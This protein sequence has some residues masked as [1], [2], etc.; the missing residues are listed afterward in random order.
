MGTIVRK[1]SK[2]SEAFLKEG[3]ANGRLIPAIARHMMTAVPEFRRQDVLHPS[4]M[5]KKDWCPLGGYRQ[6]QGWTAKKESIT[7][8]R[9]NI[10]DEGHAIHDKWQTRIAQM[11]N[12]YGVWQC[13]VCE[14]KWWDTSPG[15]CIACGSYLLKYREVPVE[16]KRTRIGGHTDGWVKGQGP[17]YMLEIKSV[18]TGSYRFD[19]PDMVEKYGNDAM[20]LWK[21]TRRP[22]TSHLKQ[23]QIYLRLANETMES[24]PQSIIFLYESKAHQ[25]Y[26]EFE[27]AY[28]PTF[29]EDRWVQA[30]DIVTRI[31]RKDIAPN[32][33]RGPAGCPDCNM[34][35]RPGTN[36]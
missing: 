13:L 17:D 36:V 7:L 23:G 18:G 27:I 28:D 33:V 1:P 24:A 19:A 14:T 32:C 5:A 11:G 20:D 30:L 2:A 8:R 9:Q 29:V 21:N 22:F 34:Y 4:A 6:L 12:L 35:T 3:R 16:C 15:A 31:E 10:F 25:D 26:K